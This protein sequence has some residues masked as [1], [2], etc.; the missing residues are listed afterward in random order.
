MS[1]ALGVFFGTGGG[2]EPAAAALFQ[3]AGGYIA[4]GENPGKS[5]TPQWARRR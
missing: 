4:K 3:R 2:G 5:V 1:R